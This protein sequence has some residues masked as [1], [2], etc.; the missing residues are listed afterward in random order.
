M[1]KDEYTLEELA[2]LLDLHPRTI[3]SYIQQGLLRGPDSRGRH[4]RYSEY[5]LRRL[6]KI[7]ELKE[8]QGMKL[9]E[10]RRT[11]TVAGSE[12]P[13]MSPPR[14][15]EPLQKEEASAPMGEPSTALEFVRAR[16]ALARGGEQTTEP[17]APML[18]RKRVKQ[19]GPLER[20]LEELRQR[21]SGSGVER[22]ARGE[23]WIRLEVTPDVEIH[24]R[25]HLSQEQLASF[26]QLA[27][28]I[29]HFLLGS[30]DHE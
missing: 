21:P 25:G 16:R 17:P 23:E 19:T 7:K 30:E 15:A 28:Y 18:S 2:K 5:H 10:I 1:S 26:E 22:K 29:R 20:L 11:L 6:E 8:V 4:A 9:D 27:D 12:E 14:S 3:R 24:V 13:A